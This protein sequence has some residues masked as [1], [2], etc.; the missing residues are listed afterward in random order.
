MNTAL[1]LEKADS[2]LAA[3]EATADAA[4][5][6]EA[7]WVVHKF[8]GSS[9]ADAARI[10]HVAW[11]LSTRRSERQVVVVSAVKGDTD[12]LLSLLEAGRDAR[13]F[14]ADRLDELSR[15]H[16]ALIRDLAHGMEQPFL[17]EALDRDIVRIRN[18]L[19][20]ADSFG[21]YPEELPAVISGYGEIWSCRLVAAHLRS[22]GVSVRELQAGD[23]I[24]LTSPD[25]ANTVHWESSRRAFG[26]ADAY[27]FADTL[28]APG[29]VASTTE[30]QPT[31]LGRNGS[32]CSAVILAALCGANITH[33]WTDVDGVLTADPRRLSQ[34]TVTSPFL[35]FDEAAELA[36]LGA[37][38]LHPATLQIAARHG[39]KVFVRNSFNPDG[40]CTLVQESVVPS[41]GVKGVSADDQVLVLTV[42]AETEVHLEEACHQLERQFRSEGI[43]PLAIL[44]A[45]APRRVSFV[46]PGSQREGALQ[47]GNHLLQLPHLARHLDPLNWSE[48]Y[49]LLGIVMTHPTLR[50]RA[51]AQFLQVLDRIGVIVSGAVQDP[52]GSGT[53]ALIERREL[54][55]ALRCVHDA[56]CTPRTEITVGVIGVGNIGRTL[57]QQITD[58]RQRSLKN[59]AGLSVRAISNSRGILFG[60]GPLTLADWESSQHG[61][62]RSGLES[63]DLEGLPERLRHGTATT[64][65]I[66]DLTASP[67]VA[68]HHR[69]WLQAGAHVVTANKLGCTGDMR[70]YR[71]LHAPNVGRCIYAYETTVGAALPVLR[72]IRDLRETGDRVVKIRGLLSGTLSYLFNTFDGSRPFSTLLREA[73]GLGLTEPDPRTDLGG[74]DVARKLLILARTAGIELELEQIEIENL[75]PASF[76]ACSLEDFYG[77]CEVLDRVLQLRL[78]EAFVSGGVLRYVAEVDHKGKASVGLQVFPKSHQLAQVAHADNFIEIHSERYQP[79]PL[80]IRGP[81]AGGELTAAGVLTDILRLAELEVSRI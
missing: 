76:A 48:R 4:L 22:C 8:G 6:G 21:D 74:L 16:Q 13:A 75:V 39:I 79:N 66:V 12:K 41:T 40:A 69:S 18:L 36:R 72:T 73:Q 19:E 35:T 11:L 56:L 31:T 29:F 25:D 23:I 68:G 58:H 44:R 33:I 61:E 42:T 57:L 9:V 43:T 60:N 28:V 26:A 24:R 5:Q 30:G 50:A 38:V 78:I 1:A 32:D 3:G 77:R 34:P 7:N 47:A 70:H 20:A 53:F 65:I 63:P 15:R 81:G 51:S 71:E 45:G 2:H 46:L 62:G 10:R 80:V 14:V 27:G 52:A 17:L 67:E 64:P 37:K 59:Q 54:Q 49:A 55:H